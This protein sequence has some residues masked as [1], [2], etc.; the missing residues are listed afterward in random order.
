MPAQA[1]TWD[2]FVEAAKQLTIDANG[3]HPGDADFDAENIQQWGVSWPTWSLPRETLI[4]SNGGDAWTED[5]TS[6]LGEPAAVGGDPGAGRPRQRPQGCA[7]DARRL[8]S[9]V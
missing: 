7:A 2:Q 4:Y 6:K 8:S 3:Q 1:W 5:F 9:S